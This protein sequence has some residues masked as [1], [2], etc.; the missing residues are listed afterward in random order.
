MPA[1][2]RATPLFAERRKKK[3]KKNKN[4]ISVALCT[5]GLSGFLLCVGTGFPLPISSGLEAAGALHG[6]GVG[7][8]VGGC[9]ATLLP[10]PRATGTEPPTR[11]RCTLAQAGALPADGGTT[12]RAQGKQGP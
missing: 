9:R 2:A 12:G 1:T 6:P 3:E 8:G 7:R 4:P 11:G 10:S 5:S